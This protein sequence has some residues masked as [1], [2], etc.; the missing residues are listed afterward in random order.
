MFAVLTVLF[1]ASASFAQKNIIIDTDGVIE[2][3]RVLGLAL[4]QDQ[5][6]NVR[7]LAITTVSSAVEIGQVNANVMRTL[8]L[9]S[10]SDIPVYEGADDGTVHREREGF[11]VDHGTD[12]Y[13][14][15]TQV[16]PHYDPLEKKLRYTENA[17]DAL[18]RMVRAQPGTI[19]IIA[20]GP[21]TNIAAAI[22][23]DPYFAKNLAG[24]YIIGG[25]YL[26]VG[27][28][29][30]MPNVEYNFHMD[31]EAAQTVLDEMPTQIVMVPLETFRFRYTGESFTF[32]NNNVDMSAFF[33]KGTRLSTFY[34]SM[35]QDML[36]TLSNKGLSFMFTD[37]LPLAIY[38]NPEVIVRSIEVSATVEVTGTHTRGMMVV[39]WLTQSKKKNV[40]LITQ[41]DPQK[42]LN[43]MNKMVEAS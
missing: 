32:L 41:Y 3:G 4:R 12:G 28:A 23:K 18:V 9:L 10:R 43:M 29:G 27:N 15:R 5:S 31:P 42:V 19:T 8:R 24:L 13:G 17:S 21:L 22:K 14:D 33:T 38:L 30:S 35:A 39:D 26:G 34:N 7:V 16:Y 25:N 1:L 2:D 36:T 37:E 6:Q 40:K 20:T 11:L